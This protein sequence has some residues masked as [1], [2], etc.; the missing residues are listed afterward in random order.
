MRLWWRMSG[1]LTSKLGIAGAAALVTL[2]HAAAWAAMRHF[3]A[4]FLLERF[5][6]FLILL[7]LVALT[8]AMS[9]AFGLAVAAVFER[10]DL[11][12]LLS[13]PIAP[14]TVQSVRA[15]G[16]AASSV[17]LLLFV[18]APFVNMGAWHGHPRLLLA[19]PV[20]LAIGLG[21]AGVAMAATLV[22]V[23]ALGVRRA[24]VVAQL[25]GA[26][27]GAVVLI[28]S[29]APNLLP[30]SMRASV[31]HLLKDRATGWLGAESLLALP[32][33][34]L[35]GDAA[36]AALVVAAGLATFVAAMRLTAGLFARTAQAS[37][38]A[39]AGKRTRQS[40]QGAFRTGVAASV[41]RKELVLLARDPVLI[42]KALLQVL[43]LIPLFVILVHN[44]SLAAALAPTVVVLASG[45]AGNLA[46]IT[47]SGEEAADLLGSA[48]ISR[49]RVLWLKCLAALLPVAAIVMPIVA[50]YA[51]RSPREGALV[52]AFVALGCATS[53]LMQI[54][55]AKPGSA[56][57]FKARGK[58][59]LLVGFVEVFTTLGWAAACWLALQASPWAFAMMAFASLAPGVAWVK[60]R[61]DARAGA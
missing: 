22:L 1:G 6:P 7:W 40:R 44:H 3:D 61:R 18:L 35:M 8:S 53:G 54:W 57:D 20:T 27:I 29:Q 4:G 45:L 37:S 52:A 10:G 24:R 33:R 25:M 2:L 56:R 31:A 38:E 36:D 59:N 15:L 19:Y 58:E 12:L 9:F 48:P 5:S 11:D 42:S 34:A 32:V 26:F 43:Y 21:C 49:E 17:A 28:A 46:W 41:V 23:R 55:T 50:W 16:V 13:S 30:P 60:G 47:V 39:A 51:L 14:A